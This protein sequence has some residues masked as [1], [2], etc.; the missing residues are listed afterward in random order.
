[1]IFTEGIQTYMRI[2]SFSARFS[3]SDQNDDV[4]DGFAVMIF[5]NAWVN[6]WVTGK[7]V[8]L[9]QSPTQVGCTT[10]ERTRII[11]RRNP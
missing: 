2:S 3:V 10:A 6:A 1:M 9:V 7:A 4:K 5:D 8:R 11:L